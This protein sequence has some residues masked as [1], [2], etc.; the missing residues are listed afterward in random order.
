MVDSIVNET[1]THANYLY[2]RRQLGEQENSDIRFWDWCGLSL[3]EATD[4]IEILNERAR[5]LEKDRDLSWNH[6]HARFKGGVYQTQA[7][8]DAVP[9]F[10]KAAIIPPR[11]SIHQD[12][13]RSV[14]SS[15]IMVT[16]KAQPQ[17][18]PTWRS[19]DV[20]VGSDDAW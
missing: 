19:P 11:K 7:E 18:E 6:Y 17:P 8:W 12:F 13:F 5:A 20:P 3:Q 10:V 4:K 16:A 2:L 9:L 15:H 14:V 1:V